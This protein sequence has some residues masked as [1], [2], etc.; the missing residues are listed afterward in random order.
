[1]ETIK[2]TDG[3]AAFLL[4]KGG[5]TKAKIARVSGADLELFERDLILE[6][7]GTDKQRRAAKKYSECVMAQR[8]GPVTI[9]D[10]FED[11]DLT[12]IQVPSEAVGFVTGSQGNFLRQVEEEWGTLMFF[13]DFRG[14]GERAEVRTAG[15]TTRGGR[16]AARCRRHPAR[17][18]STSTICCS[19][20]C[21]R[22]RSWS[23]ARSCSRSRRGGRS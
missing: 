17:P 14:R 1:M 5:K 2:L 21:S 7:R 6:I 10:N 8:V 16:R 13:A 22:T 15:A 23:R 4:G 19:S 11:D 3:D 9:D 12:V 18:P 20:F